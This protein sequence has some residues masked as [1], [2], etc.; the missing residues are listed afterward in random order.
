M[1]FLQSRS[2]WPIPRPRLLLILLLGTCIILSALAPTATAASRNSKDKS[3]A[4]EN[5]DFAE[6][7]DDFEEGFHAKKESPAKAK[8]SASKPT[9]AEESASKSNREDEEVVDE[10]E[11]LDTNQEILEKRKEIEIDDDEVLVEDDD[12]DSIDDDEFEYDGTSEGSRK[13][14]PGPPKLTITPVPMPIRGWQAFWAE[15]LMI[16]G[17]GIYLLNYTMGRYKNQKIAQSFFDIHWPLLE[18]NF[19]FLGDSTLKIEDE[20]GTRQFSKMSDSLFQMWCSGRL[21]CEGMLVEL[22][23]LKRQDIVALISNI[24][25]PSKDIFRCTVE[26]AKEDM[27]NI[28]LAIA[29][30]KT[31]LKISK[32]YTDLVNFCPDRKPGEKFGLPNSLVIMSELNEAISA[33]LDPKTI[34]VINK[35]APYIESIHISD[36]FTGLKT[37]EPELTKDGIAKQPEPKKLLVFTFILPVSMSGNN[38]DQALENVQPLLPLVFYTID[39]MRKIR[40]SKEGKAK[41]DKNRSKVE[42]A[43]MKQTHAARA[44][45]VAAKKEEKRRQE[46]ERILQEEDPEKQRRWE[47]KEQKR[48][49]K[50]KQP[51]LKQLKVKAM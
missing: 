34:S 4:P 32:E 29:N 12:F 43:F 19:H 50:R 16:F 6:F 44:E 41:S 51:K 3:P 25:R 20:V 28:V 40:L 15:L 42:E 46:K 5:D 10:V 23:L 9:P 38:I 21:C 8:E 35:C 49:K 39:R 37:A 30:K 14:D 33:I 17:I 31:A 7:D 48:E 45:A 11:D 1:W 27:D 22:K 26:L 47:E 2:S 24:F 36:H 18:E 13:K